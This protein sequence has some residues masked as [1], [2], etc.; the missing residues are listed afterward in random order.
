MTTHLS[1]SEHARDRTLEEIGNWAISS[2]FPVILVGDFNAGVP[3]VMS[4]LDRF[5]FEDI[6]LQIHPEWATESSGYTFNSWEPKS[7][8]DFVLYRAGKDCHLQ[9]TDAVL[10]GL[11]GTS[12]P[13]LKAVGGVSDARNTLF[14]S[15]HRFVQVEFA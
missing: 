10:L 2:D 15:D 13:G 1:L 14:A 7:R 8:I 12:F 4:I 11:D 3:E 5:G 9:I 6:S